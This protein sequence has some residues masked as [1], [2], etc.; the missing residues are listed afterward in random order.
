MIRAPLYV[1]LV[2][3]CLSTG[4]AAQGQYW[5]RIVYTQI[6][7]A[8]HVSPDA[9]SEI[10]EYL[11]AGTKI[12]VDYCGSTWCAAFWSY[13]RERELKRAR[14]FVRLADVARTPPPRREN[15]R[16]QRLIRRPGSDSTPSAR[17]R[18]DRP[19]LP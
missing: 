6:K 1:L 5:G 8:L 10:N 12:K 11:V 15:P 7:T 17:R 19:P 13:A 3:G 18:P 4:T 9:K 16:L 2:T 14:G